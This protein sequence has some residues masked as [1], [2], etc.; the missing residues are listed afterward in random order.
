MQAA[1]SQVFPWIKGDGVTHTMPIY[2]GYS[3]PHAI[4]RLDLAGKDLTDYLMRILTERGYS[5]TTT[6][7]REIVQKIKEK[8]CYVALDFEQGMATKV[9]SLEENYV[10]PDGQVITI[11]NEMF[12]CSEALFQPSFLGMESSGVHQMIYDSIMKCNVDIRRD[13]YAN[14]VLSGGNSMFP[15]IADRMQAEITALAPA[16]MKIKISAPPERNNSVWLGGSVIASLSTFK[17]FYITKADFDENGP[18]IV[19]RKCF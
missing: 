11:G 14:T 17:D 16:S 18:V 10:L 3:I 4:L 13:I 15:G 1:I 19:R 9:T 12:R 2:E 7:E 6:A 5:F 8:M